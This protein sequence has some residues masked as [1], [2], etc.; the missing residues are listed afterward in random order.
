MEALVVRDAAPVRFLSRVFSVLR[1]T[2]SDGRPWRGKV[3]PDLSGFSSMVKA[4]YCTARDAMD[5]VALRL[6]LEKHIDMP[7]ENVSA[8]ASRMPFAEEP[9]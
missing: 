5:V 1:T 7:P 9:R 6:W 2:R 3:D 8:I 4:V